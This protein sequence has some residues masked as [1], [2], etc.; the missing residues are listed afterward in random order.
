MLEL[1]GSRFLM[2]GVEINNI[3]DV[4]QKNMFPSY[5]NRQI[6]HLI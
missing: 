1:A 6:V 3:F 4:T 5:I 2:L